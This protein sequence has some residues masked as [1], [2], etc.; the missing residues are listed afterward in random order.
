[1][2]D[3]GYA[4][5]GQRTDGRFE[6]IAL[7]RALLGLTP[8]DGWEGDHVD[9]IPLNCRRSNLRRLPRK[10]RPNTQNVPR[11]S[12]TGSAYRGV[13]WYPKYQRWLAKL[14]VSKKTHFLG[15]FDSAEEA[16]EIVKAARL[17]LMPY[18][19]D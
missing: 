6:T 12:S 2:N 7:H 17:R 8:G 3:K 1:M 5:R 10:G 15:Y 11:Y 4:V 19:V 14:Q 9:R 16:N 13:Y 18:A